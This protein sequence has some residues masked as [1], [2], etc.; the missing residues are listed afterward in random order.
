MCVCLAYQSYTSSISST[1]LVD[2]G[3][4]QTISLH[5]IAHTDS[6]KTA[7]PQ[8]YLRSLTGLTVTSFGK[9]ETCWKKTYNEKVEL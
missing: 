7:M 3:Q 9:C 4:F 5:E 1:G 6:K 2:A 8:L